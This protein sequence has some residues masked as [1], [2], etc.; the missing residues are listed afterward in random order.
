M[1]NALTTAIYARLAGTETLTGTALTAQTAL[2]ALLST[3]PVS[4]LPAVFYGNLNM[5][6]EVSTSTGNRTPLYPCITFRQSGGVTD[7]RFAQQT[8]AVGKVVY[9]FEFWCDDRSILTIGSIAEY[10][11]RLLDY[12]RGIVNEFVLSTGYVYDVQAVA[13]R[14]DTYDEALH[15]WAG[16]ISYAFEEVRY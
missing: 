6:Q 10:V 1:S 12:R 11:E 4:G 7:K 3:D 2:D 15:V 8:G 13:E 16:L 9:D 14:I 5:A